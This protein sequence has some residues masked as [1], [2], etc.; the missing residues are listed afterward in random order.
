MTYG[1]AD[2]NAEGFAALEDKTAGAVRGNISNASH[3]SQ[4]LL[5]AAYEDDLY[6][7]WKQEKFGVLK[8]R[9]DCV[10]DVLSAHPEYADSF[11]ALP[12]NSGYFMCVRPVS[13][14]PERIRRRLLED[15]DTGVIATGGLIRVAFSS[16]PTSVLPDLFENLHLACQA[17]ARDQN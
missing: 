8:A 11:T 4:S 7:R 1:G 9:Y 12:F 2:L 3:L 15:Y 5:L 6:G 17:E 13:G 14:D 16:A 10:R